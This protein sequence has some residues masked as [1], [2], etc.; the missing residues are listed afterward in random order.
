MGIRRWGAM[1]GMYKGMGG[2]VGRGG[3]GGMG[4][5]VGHLF[6]YKRFLAY[7]FLDVD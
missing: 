1:S 6:L 2:C 4:C 7:R 5:G 3:D